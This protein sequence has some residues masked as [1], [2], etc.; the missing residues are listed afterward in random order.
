MSVSYR[1]QTARVT[2]ARHARAGEMCQDAALCGVRGELAFYGLADGQSGARFGLE[3]AQ[4]ALTVIRDYIGRRGL[5][6]LASYVYTDEIQY[7]LAQ[8][9]RREFPW[10]GGGCRF[11][12][13]SRWQHAWEGRFRSDSRQ[14]PARRGGDRF[15][16]DGGGVRCLPPD[17]AVYDGAPRRR[18]DPR[19]EG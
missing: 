18:G 5:T 10:Q 11:C 16:L 13:R 1:A 2:G 14:P 12:C 17:G 19:R 9:L 6:L 15:R 4:A 8:L 7:E 3:G